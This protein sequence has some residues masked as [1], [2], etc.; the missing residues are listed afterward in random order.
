[1]APSPAFKE[2]GH[3]R[4]GLENETVID[5]TDITRVRAALKGKASDTDDDT[6][7]GHLITLVSQDAM[8]KMN[9]AVE[10]KERTEYHDVYSGHNSFFVL[11]SPIDTGET[12]TVVHN[13]EKPRDWS[14]S[15]DEVS[16]DYILFEGD[17]A[18][19]GEIVI[20]RSLTPA[21]NALKITYTGGMGANTSA[22]TGSQAYKSL[23]TAVTL[24]VAYL[25]Q[26][27]STWG[28]TKQNVGDGQ[29]TWDGAITWRKWLEEIVRSYGR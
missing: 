23:V 24:Q 3:M 18:E 17:Y 20:E 1:M 11:A 29:I 4:S 10:K 7:L 28:L 22:I 26:R 6:L 27:R 16:S 13:T 15:A 2:A 5:L 8:F 12:I 9:R 14:D 25:W 21:P 19:R